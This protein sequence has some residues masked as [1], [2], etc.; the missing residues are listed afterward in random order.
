MIVPNAAL[1]W[2]FVLVLIAAPYC[3]ARGIADIRQRR[4]GWGV[5]GLLIGIVLAAS[6]FISTSIRVELPPLPPATR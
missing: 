4:Y 3:I 2:T 5:V 1:A 6:L